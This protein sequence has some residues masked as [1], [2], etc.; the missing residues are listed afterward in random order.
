MSSRNIDLDALA[1]QRAEGRG[2]PPTIT[3]KG[4]AFELPVEM[5]I[6][7]VEAWNAD[8]DAVTFGK[9]VLGDQW[10]RFRALRP[11]REDI[12]LGIGSKLLALW[13]VSSG[14]SKASDE[15]SSSDGTSSR[16]TSSASTGST[17]ER[18]SGAK[19]PSAPAA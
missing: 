16:P 1:A 18:Q 3:F 19:Q 15:S 13:G 9:A 5:P 8:A 17:S 4:E 14:E 10:E 6:E 7:V 11:S 2:E 12:L